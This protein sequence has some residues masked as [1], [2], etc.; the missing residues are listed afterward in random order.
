M[1]GRFSACYCPVRAS[2][3]RRYLPASSA[4]EDSAAPED[5]AATPPAR[6]AGERPT[7]ANTPRDSIYAVHNK[8]VLAVLANPNGIQPA[9]H[10][11]QAAGFHEV[12]EKSLQA[13][14]FVFGCGL[15]GL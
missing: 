8:R 12:L 3:I 15:P 13:F 5:I 10:V 1:Q 2:R 11:T 6:Y 7:P 9:F 4:A 14:D